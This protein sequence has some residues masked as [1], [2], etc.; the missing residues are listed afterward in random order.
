VI[1]VFNHRGLTVYESTGFENPWDGTFKGELLPVD[2]YFY[3]ID[4]KLL[5]QKT[6]K[7]TVTILH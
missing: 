1:K 6:Y 3:T 2:T 4:L 7:G 5:N